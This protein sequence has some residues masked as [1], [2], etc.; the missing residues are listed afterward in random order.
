MPGLSL[1]TMCDVPNRVQVILPGILYV[2]H[3]RFDPPPPPPPPRHP[4]IRESLGMTRV[5]S[6]VIRIQNN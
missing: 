6:H 5:K 4:H 1:V 2:D 3:V